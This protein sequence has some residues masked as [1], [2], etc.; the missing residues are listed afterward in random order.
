MG[1]RQSL[2]ERYSLRWHMAGILALTVLF[3]TLGNFVLRKYDGMSAMHVRY[4]LA[5]FC[6]YVSFF[7]WIR[8]RAG[9]VLPSGRRR[10][11][12]FDDGGTEADVLLAAAPPPPRGS[13][14]TK[15]GLSLGGDSDGA[16]RLAQVMAHECPNR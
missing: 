8:L 5:V 10:S 15:G 13:S 6:A 2:V 1:F 12:S 11:S 4:P 3:G 7:V 16:V 14:S 9:L